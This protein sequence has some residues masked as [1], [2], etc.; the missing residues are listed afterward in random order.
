MTIREYAEISGYA[1]A[2][3]LVR[4]DLVR[5]W[6]GGLIYDSKLYTENL[7]RYGCGLGSG[8][9]INDNN[10]LILNDL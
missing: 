9:E 7:C 4:S 2:K 3:I 6:Q 10:T 8:L 5:G 1:K